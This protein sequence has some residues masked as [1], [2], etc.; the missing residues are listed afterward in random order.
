[1]YLN[2]NL[3]LL[4]LLLFLLENWNCFYSSFACSLIYNAGQCFNFHY[5]FTWFVLQLVYRSSYD[6]WSWCHFQQALGWRKLLVSCD[7]IDAENDAA[8]CPSVSSVFRCILTKR[9]WSKAGI[10]LSPFKYKAMHY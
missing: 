2:M 6:R 5:V 10:S 4:P 7:T 9:K 1:M 3:Q 8:H